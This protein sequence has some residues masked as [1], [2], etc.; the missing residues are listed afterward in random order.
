MQ[1]R[2]EAAYAYA[3]CMEDFF[4]GARFLG[5]ILS[6]TPSPFAFWRVAPS[7][8]PSALAIA[9]AGSLRAIRLRRRRSSLDHDLRSG[10]F[11][12]L[13]AALATFPP[14]WWICN[15]NEIMHA[16]HLLAT[17]VAGLGFL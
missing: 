17:H 15:G 6:E 8:R 13:V 14:V 16:P 9:A 11:F 4:A 3:G 2:F 10:V 12:F 7:V 5:L 1:W